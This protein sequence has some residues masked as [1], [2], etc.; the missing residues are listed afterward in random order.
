MSDC[1]FSA[2]RQFSVSQQLGLGEDAEKNGWRERAM[3]A[4]LSPPQNRWGLWSTWSTSRI[5]GVR[6][7]SKSVRAGEEEET[8]VSACATWNSRCEI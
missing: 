2:Y 7:K 3:P 1:N 4:I 6:R 5:R 8:T